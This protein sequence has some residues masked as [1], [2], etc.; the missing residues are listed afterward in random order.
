MCE[1]DPLGTIAFFR[2]RHR[3]ES[4]TTLR[5]LAALPLDRLSYSPHPQSPSAG[6]TAWTIVRGL[7]LCTD[8]LRCSAAAVSRE[9]H[10]EHVNLA[11]EFETSSS[12]LADGLLGLKQ[13]DWMVE[14]MVTSDGAIILAQPLGQILWLFHF[15]SLHHRG[16]LSTYLRPLRARVPSIYGPSGDEPAR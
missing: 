1:Y 3:V 13:Q 16:Q 6:T 15:D 8:L 10:P 11:A 2:E 9:I 12:L 14:R 7:N 5:V 4:R